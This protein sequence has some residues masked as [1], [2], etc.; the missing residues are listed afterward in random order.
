MIIEHVGRDRWPQ[1]TPTAVE[2][3][4]AWAYRYALITGQTP[5]RNLPKKEA[6]Q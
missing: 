3:Y 1:P 6:K 2:R 4:A 5:V